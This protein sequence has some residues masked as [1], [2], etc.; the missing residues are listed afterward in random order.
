MV[1]DTVLRL[2]MKIWMMTRSQRIMVA[3]TAWWH[4]YI[5]SSVRRR[6]TLWLPPRSQ[7]IVLWKYFQKEALTNPQEIGQFIFVIQRPSTQTAMKHSFWRT[8]VPLGGQVMAGDTVLCWMAMVAN[9]IIIYHQGFGN[10]W[11]TLTAT[12]FYNQLSCWN[13]LIDSWLIGDQDETDE[14]RRDPISY[15]RHEWVWKEVP[16]ACC[17]F[18]QYLG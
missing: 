18:S 13:S 8:V 9:D 1:V 2:S 15:S 7:E 10:I 6:T 16:L 11:I 3:S 17:W 14:F 5:G 4:W 12:H